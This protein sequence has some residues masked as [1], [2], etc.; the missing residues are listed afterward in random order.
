MISTMVCSQGPN[1]F[2]KLHIDIH[3][4]SCMRKAGMGQWFTAHYSAAGAHLVFI[5]HTVL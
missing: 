4:T 5:S 3:V 2:V 1:P